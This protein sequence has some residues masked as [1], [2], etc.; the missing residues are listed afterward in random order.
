MGEKEFL[1]CLGL[2]WEFLL[3]ALCW[4]EWLTDRTSCEEVES[5]L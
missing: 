1:P 3:V 5:L 4:M 2:E